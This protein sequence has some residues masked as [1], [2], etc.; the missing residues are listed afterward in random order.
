M[1][2]LSLEHDIGN[3]GENSQGDTFLDN[4]QLYQCEGAP[5]TLKAQTV[6]RNLA[7]VFKE[8]NHPRKEDDAN[9]R[10]V[11]ADSRL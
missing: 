9:E 1:Q 3:D 10:P 5:I 4:L 2:I 11:A 8:G 6:G 7:A